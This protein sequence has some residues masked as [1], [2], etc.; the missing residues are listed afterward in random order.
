MPLSRVIA[1]AG[2]DHVY[3]DLGLPHADARSLAADAAAKRGPAYGEDLIASARLAIEI[4]EGDLEAAKVVLET[5]VLG[6][7]KP[8]G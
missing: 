1:V 3:R 5:L 8:A 6:A 4:A 2:S 7:K